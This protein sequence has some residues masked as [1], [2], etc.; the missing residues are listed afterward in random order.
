MT[1][2]SPTLARTCTATSRSPR[3]QSIKRHSSGPEKVESLATVNLEM[4]LKGVPGIKIL[5]KLMKYLVQ[6]G[7]TPQF[8]SN[9]LSDVADAVDDKKAEV[10]REVTDF[11]RKIIAGAFAIRSYDYFRL[12]PP[13]REDNL[14]IDPV[15]LACAVTERVR[16]FAVMVTLN[17]VGMRLPAGLGKVWESK[18]KAVRQSDAQLEVSVRMLDPADRDGICTYV[19]AITNVPGEEGGAAAS[20]KDTTERRRR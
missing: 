3:R 11:V 5:S 10:R 19:R 7:V 14:H 2:T 13:Q 18:L 20:S 16:S 6:T 4:Y 12:N 8:I 17:K 9:K 15:S 1:G